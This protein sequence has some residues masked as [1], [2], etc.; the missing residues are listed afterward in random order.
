M[1]NKNI[2]RLLFLFSFC[3]LF[4]SQ[5]YSQS[6]SQSEE[7]FFN[8]LA[9]DTFVIALRHFTQKEYE[10]A[11]QGFQQIQHL[12][13]NQRTTASKIMSA[14]TLLYLGRYNESILA[15]QNFLEQ[16]QKSAYREDAY[17]ILGLNAYYLGKYPSATE[18]FLHTFSIAKEPLNKKRSQ[19]AVEY[20]VE[21]I[22]SQENIQ[23]INS[24][25]T[26]PSSQALLFFAVAQKQITSE[27]KDDAIVLFKNIITL[28]GDNE[29]T[30]QANKLLAKLQ[31]TASVKIGVLLP[32]MK[33]SFNNA[34]ETKIATEILE[35][36]QFAVDVYNSSS[37]RT[38]PSI[39]LDIRDSQRKKETIRSVFQEWSNDT[40]LI[41]IIGPI[42]SDEVLSAI[43]ISST[44]KI[45]LIS[46]TATD[47]GLAS[48][49]PYTYQVNPDFAMRGKMMARY[50][51]QNLGYTNFAI[52]TSETPT[53]TILAKS[54]AKE[55]A[56]LGGKIL[57]QQ[58]YTKGTTDLR[59]IFRAVRYDVA[60]FEIDYNVSLSPKNRTPE[61]KMNLISAG[62]FSPMVDSLFEKSKNV[63]LSKLLGHRNKKTADSLGLLTAEI[64]FYTD[65]LD[66]PVKTIEA[67]FC[68]I[69]QSS[70]V[71]IISSQIHNLP[72]SSYPH[73]P[74]TKN[75]THNP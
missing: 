71:G 17:F 68:P 41:G 73:V 9:D 7:V 46:P 65:S 22:L 55:V 75:K 24:S 50:A 15:A 13:R 4:F 32:L 52:I 62:A 38:T 67:V 51:V 54:F 12:S 35:G 56:A 40:T 10:K 28:N 33:A 21:E 37:T 43:K 23:Q 20:L 30:Y 39:V 8:Q 31:N 34:R 5:L 59:H 49:Y 60:P 66:F 70:E 58:F 29:I 16:E 45:P 57:S 1:Y 14:K 11:Y 47:T 64:P 72:Y 63:T 3:V 25:T 74:P 48:T 42:F 36:I 18:Y 61:M 26:I 2:I 53:N 27:K 6:Y 19:K 69:T 44:T